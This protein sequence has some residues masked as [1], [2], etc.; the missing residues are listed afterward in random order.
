MADSNQPDSKQPRWSFSL[1]TL[2]LL[3]VP[4]ALV[5]G[6]Y[7]YGLERLLFPTTV[8]SKNSFTPEEVAILTSVLEFELPATARIDFASYDKQF[9]PGGGNITVRVQMSVDDVTE[10]GDLFRRLGF[11][12][13][14]DIAPFVLTCPLPEW[15]DANQDLAYYVRLKNAH[16]YVSKPHDGQT[17][18]YFDFEDL[19][20]SQSPS[21]LLHTGERRTALPSK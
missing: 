9:G 18:V 16:L 7:S 8:Y 19:S 5:F 2:L 20:E 3:F 13:T 15:R 1:R 14:K 17:T 11:H 21:R 10:L 12:T 4:I 6:L